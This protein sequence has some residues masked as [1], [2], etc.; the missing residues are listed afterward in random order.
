MLA[1]FN[2]ANYLHVYL[3]YYHCIDIRVVFKNV[4]KTLLRIPLVLLLTS[5]YV[6][7]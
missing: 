3:F 5:A 2:C 7:I 1:I 6:V 4:S